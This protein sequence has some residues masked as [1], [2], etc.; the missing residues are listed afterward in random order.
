VST[1]RARR[2]PTLSTRWTRLYAARC[3]TCAPDRWTGA[4]SSSGAQAR[5]ESVREGAR[6]PSGARRRVRGRRTAEDRPHGRGS[7]SR[8]R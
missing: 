6:A 4:T 5:S 7:A 3:T 8:R 1:R 2:A